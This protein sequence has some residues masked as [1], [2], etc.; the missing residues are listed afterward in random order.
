MPGLPALTLF[1]SFFLLV[2][3]EARPAAGAGFH[4]GVCTGT[5]T[6]QEDDLRGAEQLIKEH[7][8]VAKGGMVRHLTFPDD[9]MSQQ[10][11]VISSLVSLADDPRMK[12]VV[13]CQAIP[14][15]AEAFLQIRARHPDILLLAGLPHEDPLVIQKAAHLVVDTDNVSRGLRVRQGLP[16]HHPAGDPPALPDPQ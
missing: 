14:G 15:V 3:C 9:F 7:G 6:Q 12:V 16:G 8:S 2:S 13:V 5:V 1:F 10:E 4:I 11:T